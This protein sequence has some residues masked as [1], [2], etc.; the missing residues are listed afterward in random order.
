MNFG[1]AKSQRPFKSSLRVFLL[2]RFR[3]L[4][5]PREHRP[6]VRKPR[7]RK[8]NICQLIEANVITPGVG[9]I[10]IRGKESEL[11]AELTR[12][13]KIVFNGVTFKSPSAFAKS[14]LS[15]AQCSGWVHTMYRAEG[16]ESWRS[17]D[18]VRDCNVVN[19]STVPGKAWSAQDV[20]RIVAQLSCVGAPMSDAPATVEDATDRQIQD[21]GTTNR[22]A[23][24][25]E[26]AI[27]VATDDNTKTTIPCPA[28]SLGLV[29]WVAKS[30]VSLGN[31]TLADVK[32]MLEAIVAAAEALCPREPQA[33]S[34]SAKASASKQRQVRAKKQAEPHGR[35]N[36]RPS[37]NRGRPKRSIII[38][39]FCCTHGQN[40]HK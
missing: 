24:T 37:K 3:Q 26:T 4:V 27:L 11:T 8:A 14:V 18:S 1:V 9:V 40:K 34:L 25:T 20:E 22:K 21:N 35:P 39:C 5:D 17:L 19:L 2:S 6:K 12:E 33:K 36:G 16:S 32:A 31:K 23:N 38:F 29:D 15:R 30:K 7:T 28:F 13:G 10:S